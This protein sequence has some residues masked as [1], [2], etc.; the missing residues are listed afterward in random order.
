MLLTVIVPVYNV[1]TYLDRCVLSI[2]Q[3]TYKKLEI[4]LVDDGSTDQSPQMCDDWFWKDSRIKVIHKKNGGL[5]SARNVGLNAASGEVLSFIDSDDF[6]E[7]DMYQT[8]MDAMKESGKDI[9]SCGRI[10][11]LW[12]KREKIEFALSQPRIYTRKEAIKEVLCLRELD[13]SACDKLY[14]KT[15]F[16]DIRYP[17]GKIS[18]DAA[19]IFQLLNKSNG[20]VHVGENFYHYIFRRSSISKAA[21]SHVK[22]DAYENCLHIIEFFQQHYPDMESYVKLYNTMT[23]AN[24]LE[25]MYLDPKSIVTYKA[26]FDEYNVMFRAGFAVAMRQTGLSKKL[27]VRLIFIRL[28]RIAW[29]IKLKKFL[30]R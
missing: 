28:G 18:E 17:E 19:I 1:E 13:V 3:Q 14:K 6:I 25:S 2:T 24:L 23:C 8:M 21:Y 10:V 29:F 26:D 5:S 15:L 16:F 12:G 7:L 4:I 22:Y 20:L 30:G 11:D 27:K 9:A